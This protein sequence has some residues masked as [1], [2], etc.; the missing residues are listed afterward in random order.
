MFYSNLY[1]YSKFQRE[2]STTL[3]LF[4]YLILQNLEHSNNHTAIAFQSIINVS[5]GPHGDLNNHIYLTST[6]V[7]RPVFRE[8]DTQYRFTGL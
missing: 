7:L 6:A 2:Q 5:E 8:R 1:G 4:I 3:K